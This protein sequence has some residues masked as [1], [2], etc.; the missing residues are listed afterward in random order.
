MCG[1]PSRTPSWRSGPQPRHVPR[2]GIKLVSLWF[3]VRCSIHRATPARAEINLCF[4]CSCKLFTLPHLPCFSLWQYSTTHEPIQL[5]RDTWAL[6]SFWTFSHMPPGTC[7]QEIL[8]GMYRGVELQ[9]L[10]VCYSSV[11]L[12]N[13]QTD[14]CINLPSHLP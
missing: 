11:L 7:V 14:G 1:C 2:L 5:L 6:S 4:M 8:Q 13:S 9:S 12:D 3:V 10:S